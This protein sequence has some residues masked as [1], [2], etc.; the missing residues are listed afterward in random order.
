METS[1]LTEI[2]RLAEYA[3]K[4]IENMAQ[5]A[6]DRAELAIAEAIQSLITEGEKI[7]AKLQQVSLAK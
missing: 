6:N 2:D 3:R 5:Q 1:N 7:I 4:D